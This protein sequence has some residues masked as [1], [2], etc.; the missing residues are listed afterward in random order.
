MSKGKQN[1]PMPGKGS[2]TMIKRAIILQNAEKEGPG[3]L[4]DI[5]QDRGWKPRIIHLY[6]GVPIPDNWEEIGLAIMMGGPMNV[7]DE[8]VYPFLKKE[9]EFIREAVKRGLPLLGICLGGQLIANALGAGVYRGPVK[10]I[11]W[12]NVWLTPEGR[13]DPLL[14]YFP[15]DFLVFQWHEDAMYLPDGAI[16]L[17]VSDRYHNQAFR[18]GEWVYA[19]QFHLE[20]TQT[21]IKSWL[22]DGGIGLLS[23]KGTSPSERILSEAS[24][25]LNKLHILCRNFFYAF[26]KKIEEVPSPA[27]ED[28]E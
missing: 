5:L 4:L 24:L 15:S 20:V 3:I 18:L 11:G 2:V 27:V 7:H 9:K 16:H 19:L 22:C 8:T 17:V 25:Y 1:V 10:E 26:L 13:R 14:A 12:S 6:Q 23:S 21:I 28:I